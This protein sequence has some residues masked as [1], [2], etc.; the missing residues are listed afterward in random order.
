M[1]ELHGASFPACVFDSCVYLSIQSE[2]IS[3]QMASRAVFKPNCPV[4]RWDMS[5]LLVQLGLRFF[6]HFPCLQFLPHLV[7]PISTSFPVPASHI[8]VK[9]IWICKC[10]IKWQSRCVTARTEWGQYGHVDTPCMQRKQQAP[11][12]CLQTCLI[13]SWMPGSLPGVTAW[14]WT[15]FRKL[16]I[17]IRNHDMVSSMTEESQKQQWMPCVLPVLEGHSWFQ[18]RAHLVRFI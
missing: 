10:Y 11:S 14:K 7:C 3:Q 4:V 5:S 12:G 17:F 16:V 9:Q 8:L 13:T 1:V 18:G 2:Q 15:Q 6:S